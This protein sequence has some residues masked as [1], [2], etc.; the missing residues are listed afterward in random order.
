M[1]SACTTIAEIQR[2]TSEWLGLAPEQL[3]SL[4]RK[5]EVASARHVAMY[6]SREL[7]DASLPTIGRAFGGRNHTTVLHAL[8]RVRSRIAT[9]VEDY[10]LV[11][12]LTE[13]IEHPPSPAHDA[14]EDALVQMVGRQTRA[15]ERLAVATAAL[16]VHLARR[17]R[18]LDALETRAD[19]WASAAA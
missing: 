7:T 16:D 4:D 11:H 2:L 1:N 12:D 17:L 3:L 14:H 6:L 19:A 13:R 15:L 18:R 10:W 8:R 5:A 9:S